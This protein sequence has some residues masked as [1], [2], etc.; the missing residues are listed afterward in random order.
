MAA[1]KG[2][3]VLISLNDNMNFW[4]YE[5]EKLETITLISIISIRLLVY[6]PNHDEQNPYFVTKFCEQG[7]KWLTNKVH[8][9]CVKAIIIPATGSGGEPP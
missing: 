4:L 2:Q 5:Q 6:L 7:K 3:A 9:I 8:K 1:L